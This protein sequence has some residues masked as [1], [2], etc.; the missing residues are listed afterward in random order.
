[1]RHGDYTRGE[2][3][4]PYD[5]DPSESKTSRSLPLELDFAL[6]TIEKRCRRDAPA[7][8]ESTGLADF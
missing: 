2:N 1:M 8:R 3:S 4:V 6:E 5:G 7:F